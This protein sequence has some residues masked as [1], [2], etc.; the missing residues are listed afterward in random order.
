MQ[1]QGDEAAG[2]QT[3]RHH[4]GGTPDSESKDTG[5]GL[6]DGRGEGRQHV[7]ALGLSSEI[8]NPKPYLKESWVKLVNPTKIYWLSLEKHRLVCILFI[9]N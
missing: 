8:Q 5:I 4:L 2:T 7:P 1:S 9:V 6:L 3:L